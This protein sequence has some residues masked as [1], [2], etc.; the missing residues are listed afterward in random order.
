M[1]DTFKTLQFIVHLL[2]G[3]SYINSKG[4]NVTLFGTL[5]VSNKDFI[6]YQFYCKDKLYIEFSVKNNVGNLYESSSYLRIS[7]LFMRKLKK[8]KLKDIIGTVCV[9][10][11]ND[12]CLE[13]IEKTIGAMILDQI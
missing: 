1:R 8:T 5:D 4:Y 2:D 3:F 12:G 6:Q 7:K 11:N 10:R 9:A 13:V